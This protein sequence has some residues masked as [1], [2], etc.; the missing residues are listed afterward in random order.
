V[1]EAMRREP[2]PGEI[3]TPLFNAIWN[4]VKDWEVNDGGVKWSVTGN[5]VCEIID[6]VTPKEHLK[7]I[8]QFLLEM[9]Q[10]MVDPVEEFHG[11][12]EELCELLLKRAREDRQALE[13]YSQGRRP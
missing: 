7:Y 9:Y 2:R 11:N 3:E 6:A 4:V 13:D 12:I 5:D 10:T 8:Q 1:E